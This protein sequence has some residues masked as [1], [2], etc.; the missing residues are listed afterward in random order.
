MVRGHPRHDA[1]ES[2]NLWCREIEN[3]AIDRSDRTANGFGRSY[4]GSRPTGEP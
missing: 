1:A 2:A 4:R 3:P